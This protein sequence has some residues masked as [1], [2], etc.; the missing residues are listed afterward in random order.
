MNIGTKIVL[1]GCI[2]CITFVAGYLTGSISGYDARFTSQTHTETTTDT[3]FDS[4]NPA[5]K[6]LQT[7]NKNTLSTASSVDIHTA[8]TTSQVGVD[9][10]IDK[11]SSGPAEYDIITL[12]NEFVAYAGS[13]SDY[14]NYGKKIDD[15]RQ[16]LVSSS[17]DLAVLVEYF[18]ELP[19]DSQA[20]YMLVSIIM[21]LP[22][23]ISHPAMQRIM[24]TA[25]LNDDPNNAANFVELA[26]RTGLKST[27]IINSLKNIAIFG[28]QNEQTLRALDMLMPYDLNNT[29]NQQIRERLRAAVDSSEL[30]ERPYYFSQLLRF[31]TASEREQLALDAFTKTDN[32]KDIQSIIM[33]SIQVGTLD[34]TIELK[35]AL[36]RIAKQDQHDL[37]KQAIYTLL[38]RF[39]LSQEEYRD[40]SEGKNLQQDVIFDIVH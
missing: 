25:L 2:L 15:I 8:Q 31:S 7:L 38:Y 23:E 12:F 16:I 21:G 18:E 37:Q 35:E 22:Q 28:S 20:S 19:I 14:S 34:R 32:N 6:P 26:A 33:D 24:Q 36:Y 5:N 17:A 10:T 3:A 29:E 30:S 11:Q 40:I 27:E 1:I 39:D 9:T 4:A 13:G